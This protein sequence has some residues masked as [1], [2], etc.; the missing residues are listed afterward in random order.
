[1]ATKRIP[2]FFVL[3]KWLEGDLV[4][5]KGIAPN[6]V[7]PVTFAQKVLVMDK[8]TDNVLPLDKLVKESYPKAKAVFTYQP[9][10]KPGVVDKDMDAH[11]K[12]NYGVKT[13]EDKV[14]LLRALRNKKQVA[15]C[16]ILQY[17]DPSCVFNVFGLALVITKQLT[18]AAGATLDLD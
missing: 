15:V 1:M 4:P 13:S 8:R 17:D 7:F 6:D 16:F 2:P 9:W 3:E 14:R 11:Q 18:V 5:Y 10:K 12:S